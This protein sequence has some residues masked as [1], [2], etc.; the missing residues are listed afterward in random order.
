VKV[1]FVALALSRDWA[2]ACG[3]A[4]TS[5]RASEKTAMGMKVRDFSV[6]GSPDEE[7]LLDIVPGPVKRAA[8]AASLPSEQLTEAFRFASP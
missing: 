3:E 6:S 5:N 4:E 7:R 1:S 8:E 2:R